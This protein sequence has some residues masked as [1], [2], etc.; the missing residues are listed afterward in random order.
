MLSAAHWAREGKSCI[1]IACLFA[2]VNIEGRLYLTCFCIS[3][4]LLIESPSPL[5]AALTLVSL[6][7]SGLAIPSTQRLRRS[8]ASPTAPVLGMVTFAT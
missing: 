7:F 2:H 3:V 4:P 8:W 1:T 5:P 6:P